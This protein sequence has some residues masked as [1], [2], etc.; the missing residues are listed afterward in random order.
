MQSFLEETLLTI[1]NKEGSLENLIFVLPSKRAGTFL[2]NA[3]SKHTKS[4]IFAPEILSIED[5]VENISGLAYASNTQQLFELYKAYTTTVKGEQDTFYAFSKWGTTLLQDFNEIDRYLVDTKKI[6]SHLNAVQEI[7]HWTVEKDKSTII[8][9]YMAFWNSLEALYNAFNASLKQ[10]G[11]GHQGL[12]YR[13]ACNNLEAYINSKSKQKHLFIGF[14]ALN[15]AEEL[16]IESILEKTSSEIYWDL[17]EYFFNDPVHDAGF[18]IRQFGKQWNYFKNKPLKVTNGNYLT[19][20]NITITGVPKN[21]SQAKYIGSIL[22]KLY[23]DKKSMLTNTAVVLGDETLL[24]PLINAIPEE[25]N[26]INITMGFP[27]HKSPLESLFSQ[28]FDLYIRKD[29]KGWYYQHVTTVLN[30]PYIQLLFASEDKTINAADVICNEIKIRNW[31]YV[32]VAKLKLINSGTSNL[33]LLFYKSN[34]TVPVFI[35]KCLTLILAIKEKINAEG[36]GL[37]LEYLYRFHQLFNQLNNLVVKYPFLNDLQSLFGL[38]KELLSSETLDFKGEPLKGLQIMGMLESRNLD[39]ETVLLTSVN[40][41]ILP[42]GKSNNS[43]IP[44]DI[45]KMY[46]LPTYKEKDAVYTYHF[47]R[48]LQR[49]KNIHLVYNTEPDV[50]EGGEVSRLIRQLLA[51]NNMSPYITETI[52]FPEIKSPVKK[53][54]S[55][56][57]DAHLM[58]LIKGIAAYGFSPTSL[59]NYI[60]NPLDFYKKNI[61]KINELEEVEETVAANTFGTIVH[62]TLDELY[63]PFIN[64]FLEADKLKALLPNIN[65]TVRKHFNIHYQNVS[66]DQ[67][68]NLIAYNVVL[69]YV[70]N[71]IK[72]EI[73]TSKK[74]KIKIIGLELSLKTVINVPGVNFPV[75]IKG[76]LDRIDEIDGVLRVIDY[77]TGKVEQKNLNLSTWEDIVEEYDKSKAFQLLCYAYMYNHAKPIDKVQAGIF[78]FKNIKAGILKFSDNKNTI[79]TQDTLHKFTQELHKLVGAICNSDEP[80]VAKEIK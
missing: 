1:I 80:F 41:G 3:I 79:I 43:F 40:E 22:S 69:K 68:K 19:D 8:T 67:G 74:H 26:G 44:F 49:A 54:V 45:K 16:I 53:V 52:A 55:I 6:F 48:L 71:F 33:D 56:K 38:Y 73:E 51:D 25:I 32:D 35:K 10:D 7:N 61:L 20:K 34:L 13:E 28:L 66:L 77:K 72:I 24:N 75:H 17:D 59:S 39:F 29:E 31:I 47:Y 4:T 50:L 12:V 63:K 37:E 57:K 58:E 14:N 21:V 76:K 9:N 27:L 2:K 15:T 5:F 42:S 78:S 64:T 36:N 23:N 11:L 60:R 30:H 65:S 70:E 62:E 18:F 46:G